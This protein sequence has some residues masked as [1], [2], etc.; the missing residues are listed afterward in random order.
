MNNKLNMI[1]LCFFK[2][3]NEI[4]DFDLKLHKVL[5][6]SDYQELLFQIVRIL[7]QFSSKID[8]KYYSYTVTKMIW[9]Q[10]KY[11]DH[12]LNLKKFMTPPIL[13]EAERQTIN[14]FN[15][16]DPAEINEINRLKVDTDRYIVAVGIGIQVKQLLVV[17]GS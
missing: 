6:N 14:L 2:H 4:F 13:I 17:F 11:K 10:K 1:K 7:N 16:N 3:K 9:S 5:S 15:T 12:I 8:K